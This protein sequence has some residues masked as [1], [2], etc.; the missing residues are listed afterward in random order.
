VKKMEGGQ[1]SVSSLSILFGT[2]I[3]VAYE[4]I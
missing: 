1:R 3:V 4:F 2:E